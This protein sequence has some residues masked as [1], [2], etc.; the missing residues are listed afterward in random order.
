MDS[1]NH[2]RK[3]KIT[4]EQVLALYGKK[5]VNEIA[6]E[7]GVSRTAVLDRARKL[8]ITRREERKKVD[9]EVR[10][11]QGEEIVK[12]VDEFKLQLQEWFD[13]LEQDVNDYLRM[14]HYLK[15]RIQEMINA[16]RVRPERI[17]QSFE[18]LCKIK[19]RKLKRVCCLAILISA[20]IDS[21]SDWGKKLFSYVSPRCKG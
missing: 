21:D 18:Q 9:Q 20:F 13:A 7:L 5:P 19:D 8:G 17:E 12:R 16:G 1:T 4:D 2:K 14:E 10:R 6:K 15:D 3:G 11:K